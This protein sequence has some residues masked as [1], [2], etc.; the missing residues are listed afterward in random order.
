MGL[1][2][3]L[4]WGWEWVAGSNVNKTNSASTEIEVDLRLSLA[5]TTESH[6]I[7]HEEKS[8]NSVEDF[9]ADSGKIDRPN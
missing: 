7:I 9:L 3:F 8:E 6:I 1:E 5:K 4:V 2:F